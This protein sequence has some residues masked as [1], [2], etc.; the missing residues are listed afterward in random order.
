MRQRIIMASM[1]WKII[2]SQLKQAGLTEQQIADS[3]KLSQ[4]SIHR[5]ASGEAKDTSYRSGSALMALHEY[6]V[7]RWRP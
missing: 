5:L 2:I 4:S 1:N 6:Q 7:N 3:V